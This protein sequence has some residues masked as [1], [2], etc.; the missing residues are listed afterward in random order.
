MIG[1]KTGIIKEENLP[2]QSPS[3]R[4]KEGLEG[5]KRIEL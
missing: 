5:V 3:H 4:P 1:Q 2:P